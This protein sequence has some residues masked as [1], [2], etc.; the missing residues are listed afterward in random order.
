MSQRAVIGPHSHL[1]IAV[2]R[3]HGSRVECVSIA[4]WFNHSILDHLSGFWAG[5]W[6]EHAS[7]EQSALRMLS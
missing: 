4:P 2:V 3:E 6:G 7:P 1:P 5:D